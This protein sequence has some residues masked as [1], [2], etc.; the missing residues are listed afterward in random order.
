VQRQFLTLISF[1]GLFALS[2]CA[3]FG[4]P[5]AAEPRKGDE[6]IVAGQMF[7]TGTPVVLWLDPGGYDGYRV[8]R[9]FSPLDRS[10]WKSSVED[11][12][13]LTTPNRYGLRKSVLNENE[14]QD[15]RG[16]G[17]PL[18]LL[19]EK[20]DQF[21]IHY[22]ASG[23]SRQCF[24]IL[25]DNRDLSVH[26]MLDL[27]GTIYQTLDL[28]ERAWHATTS[29]SRSI[30]I[31][32]ANIGA[33][34]PGN[35]TAL[36]R[37]YRTADGKTLI[38]IPR[39]FEPS[40]IRNS[41][42]ILHPARNEPIRGKIQDEELLQYDFTEQQYQALIK[43]TATLCKIFP[44]LPCSF[45]ENEQGKVFPEKLPDERLE[46]YHGLLGHFHVQSNKTDPGPAFDWERVVRGARTLLEPLPGN[47]K[48][49]P[50]K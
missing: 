27:D 17:W 31:E 21:V 6:I 22:D 20:V 5:G 3:R 41:N 7:H 30:G 12:P 36:E 24:K 50:Y 29:N 42:L 19:K 43:L 34:P 49:Q 26:F 48:M 16:G 35:E 32:I 45:P 13:S 14:A 40:G 18:D 33:Y 9:R 28:K 1:V 38:T 37:W 23:T 15:V 4:K 11:N 2:G 25:H 8:E 39:D 46:S 47:A 10:D 44:K